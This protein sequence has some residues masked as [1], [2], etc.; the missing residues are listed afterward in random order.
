MASFRVVTI[1]VCQRDGRTMKEIVTVYFQHVE[2]LRVA[3]VL[4]LTATNS[5]GPVGTLQRNREAE[6]CQ[7]VSAARA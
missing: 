7:R 2:Q 6:H 5:G 4:P 3:A 1:V